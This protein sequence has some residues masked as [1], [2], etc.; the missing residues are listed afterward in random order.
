MVRNMREP[1]GGHGRLSCN[2]VVAGNSDTPRHNLNSRGNQAPAKGGGLRPIGEVAAEVVA[3]HQFRR[4][5]GRLDSLRP[6]PHA[7]FPGKHDPLRTIEA[8]AV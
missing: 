7:I 5:V 3:D 1:P 8:G 4:Q 6:W 2:S